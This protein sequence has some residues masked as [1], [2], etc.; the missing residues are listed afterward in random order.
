MTDEFLPYSLPH[1]DDDDIN[2][3][4]EVL[5]SGWLTTG[6]KCE[7]F[8]SKLAEYIG[9]KYVVAVSSCS[10]ALHLACIG[11]DIGPGDEVITTPLTFAATIN[12]ILHVGAKPIFV[13]IDINTG[14]IDIDKIEEKITPKTKALLPVHYAG[15]SCDLDGLKILAE[16]YSIRII[17]DAAHAIGT[18]Y[19][20]KKVGADS[21]AAC[22][23]FY[24]IKNMT[25]IEGGA[26]ATNSETVSNL[27]RKYA[28][29]G[30][31]KDAWKRYRAEGTWFYE[32]LH[33]GFKYNLTD[34]QAALGLQQLKK[35][36][37]MIAIRNSYAEIYYDRL[38]DLKD[39][40]LP[41]REKNGVHAYQL[42]VVRVQ[43][44]AKYT[45]NDFIDKLRSRGIGTTV[46]FIPV[47][48]HPYYRDT[49]SLAIDDYPV[50][51][52]FYSQCVSLPLYPKMSIADV[53]RVCD[54]IFEIMS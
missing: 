4:V 39:L 29:H 23:S 32:V 41:P 6:P 37:S 9:C 54:T 3:V 28:L 1:I 36:D 11:F 10:A 21:D 14:L 34:V 15:M 38:R 13:D 43:E 40:V 12:Q 53:N 51:N 8:E 17:E 7:E 30:I 18:Q 22:Y 44:G 48:L 50:T 20:G 42:F 45:R 31:S 46:N 47:P 26:I 27:A 49:L 25:T 2:A 52:Q 33:C 19:K 16:K 35:L 24:P 5:K